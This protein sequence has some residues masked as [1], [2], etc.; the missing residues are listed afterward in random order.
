MTGGNPGFRFLLQIFIVVCNHWPG[1]LVAIGLLVARR[2]VAG[3][4]LDGWSLVFVAGW[5]LVSG[6]WWSA[7]CQVADRWWSAGWLV[8][9]G[10]M[11][12]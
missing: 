8:I 4:L 9:H 6:Q 12:N 5:S 11:A 2:L 3:G 1:K 7:G 10:L